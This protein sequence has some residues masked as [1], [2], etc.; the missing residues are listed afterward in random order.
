MTDDLVAESSD[1]GD[2]AG[3]NGRSDSLTDGR[4]SLA[5]LVADQ[6]NLRRPLG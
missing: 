6:E 1:H 5:D 4:A 2:M 3:S